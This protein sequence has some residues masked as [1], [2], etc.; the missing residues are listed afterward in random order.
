MFA[1]IFT[2]NGEYLFEN[3]IYM[4]N[5]IL[6][7]YITSFIFSLPHP[8]AAMWRFRHSVSLLN[9]FINAI[10]DFHL[11]K[12]KDINSVEAAAEITTS[13]ALHNN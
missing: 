10:V 8:T 1:S 4:F 12:I 3:P 9:T 5:L 6:V 7:Y 13:F 2:T 11:S